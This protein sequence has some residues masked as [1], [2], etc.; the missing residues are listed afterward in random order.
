MIALHMNN[1]SEIICP[2]KVAGQAYFLKEKNNV[3]Y[4]NSIE[5]NLKTIQI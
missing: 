1:L 5:V 3:I 2:A 4:N